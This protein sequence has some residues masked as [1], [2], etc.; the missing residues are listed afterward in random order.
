MDLA[1]KL[2]VAI[3]RENPEIKIRNMDLTLSPEP[4]AAGMTVSL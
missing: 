3:S 2:Y 1:R 4:F